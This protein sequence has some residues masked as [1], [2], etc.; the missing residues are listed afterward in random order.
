V[1][2]PPNEF[3]DAGPEHAADLIADG[4]PSNEWL[5]AFMERLSTLR[6]SGQLVD[7]LETWDLS[8]A[9]FAE[10]VGVSRQ[11]IGKW[12]VRLPTERQVAV[13]NLA[14]AND[15]LVHYVRRERI[16]AVVRRTAPALDGRSLLDLVQAD[17]T[18]QVLAAT[19]RMFDPAYA[20]A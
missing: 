14:A 1:V 12:L 9:E 6:G 10:L 2:V 11:A 19:R 16:P 4:E 5:D 20:L 15:V 17:E 3:L 8:Q 13:A 7:V 18:A